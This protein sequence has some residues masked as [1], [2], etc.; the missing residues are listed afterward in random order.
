VSLPDG[1]IG[2]FNHAGPGLIRTFDPENGTGQRRGACGQRMTPTVISTLARAVLKIG[3]EMAWVNHGEEVLDP[4]LDH[5]RDAILGRWQSGFLA[6]DRVGPGA[7]ERGHHVI[8][9]STDEADGLRLWVQVSLIGSTLVT[10]SRPGPIPDHYYDTAYVLP[11]ALSGPGS[12]VI[13][14]GLWGPPG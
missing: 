6:L 1:A 12:E 4:A 7:P 5:V 9:T 11:F 14:G 3:Y 10:A 13:G 2:V 8:T